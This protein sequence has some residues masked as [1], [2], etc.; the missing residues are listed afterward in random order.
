MDSIKFHDNKAVLAG[1]TEY[2][3]ITVDMIKTIESWKISMFSHQW[4]DQGGKIKSIN[5][6][7]EKEQEKRRAVEAALA[8]GESI[9]KPILG[10]GIQDNVEIGSGRVELLTLAAKGLQ[11]IPVHI[12]KSN[13]KD[14]KAFLAS[15]E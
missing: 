12:P 5:D 11:E 7:P 2:I 4:L 3:E 13:Q 9:T 15:V 8:R 10:M 14:F 1:Q 6:L